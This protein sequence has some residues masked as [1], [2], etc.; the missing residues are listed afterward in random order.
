MDTNFERF[1]MLA[2]RTSLKM[3][4]IFKREFDDV[5]LVCWFVRLKSN[6][7]LETAPKHVVPSFVRPSHFEA[8][9]VTGFAVL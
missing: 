2:L 9:I 1:K 8:Y 7:T 6:R 5:L 4:S 3:T